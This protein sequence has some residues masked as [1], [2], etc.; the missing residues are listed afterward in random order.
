[1]PPFQVCTDRV[2]FADLGEAHDCK[3]EQPSL[4]IFF[5]EPGVDPLPVILDLRDAEALDNFAIQEGSPYKKRE[6]AVGFQ[7]F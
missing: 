7:A 3:V 1:M 4:H 6:N 2:P 5:V